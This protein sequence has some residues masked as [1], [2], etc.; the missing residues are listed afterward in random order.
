[1]HI[2]C[3]DT[4]TALRRVRSSTSCSHHPCPISESRVGLMAFLTGKEA[5]LWIPGFYS[6]PAPSEQGI[7]PIDSL[8]PL[9]SAVDH[10]S[11]SLWSARR[12]TREICPASGPPKGR[13]LCSSSNAHIIWHGPSSSTPRFFSCPWL[14]GR[15]RVGEH[16]WLASHRRPQSARASEVA[17][18]PGSRPISVAETESFKRRP[19]AP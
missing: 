11:E 2:R 19:S 9:G 1:M 18:F 15:R 7:N 6:A 3:I 10:C 5:F 13:S 14:R 17:V 12:S 16:A 8:R 4:I